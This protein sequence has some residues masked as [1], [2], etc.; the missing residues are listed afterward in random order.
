MIGTAIS[1]LSANEAT[2]YTINDRSN[3]Q[4][5]QEQSPFYYIF[6]DSVD[7][8]YQ[9]DISYE[10]HPIPNATGEKSGDV[11]RRGKTITLSGN[12]YGRNLAK[13]EEGA[14]YL[15]TMFAEKALRKLRWTRRID[16]VQVYL[17][18]RVSQDLAVVQ[19]F[20]DG[21]YRWSWVV[22]LRADYP[23]TYKSSDNTLYPTFQQ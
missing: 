8:L 23:F 9:S 3:Q 10:S 7:G 11:F 6:V 17:K 15:Q 22:G 19:S 18:C 16:G 14:E 4:L 20:S 5:L 13:L 1:F 2:T 21:K 12:I